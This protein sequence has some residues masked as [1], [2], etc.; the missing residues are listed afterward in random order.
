MTAVDPEAGGP[1]V[2]VITLR[3]DFYAHCA[4]YDRLRQA[5]AVH[6]AYIGPMSR[7][8]LRRAIEMPARQGGWD[9]EPGLVDLFLREASDE[10]GALPLLSHA[11]LETWQR[12][13]GR[14]LT[15][16]GYA[17]SGGVRGAIAQTAESLQQRL[18]PEQQRLAR[19]IF[20][21]LTELGEGT[22]DTRRRVALS[23][24]LGSATQQAQVAALLKTL[25]DARLVTVSE[26]NVEV[27]HEALIREWPTLREW[28]NED[29]EGLRLHR[30]LTEA[31]QAW[32]GLGRE[33]GEL[34]RGVRLAQALEWA[35]ARPD[36]L[37]TLEREFL[38]ASRAEVERH[39]AELEAQ[40][41]RELK[42]AQKL[43]EAEAHTAR[44]QAAAARRLRRRAVF[45]TGALAIAAVLALA[46]VWF[47][48]QAQQEARAALAREL[49]AGAVANLTVDPERSV[50]LAL[51][52]VDT[53]YRVDGT[54]LREAENALHQTIPGLRVKLSLPGHAAAVNDIALSPDGTRLATASNDGTAMIWDLTAG[55]P[56]GANRVRA[57]L[58]GHTDWLWGA[59]YSPDGRLVATAS[60]DGT[61][62]VWD[63]ETG[64]ALLQLADLGGEVGTVDFSPD[65]QYLA[66]G[67]AAGVAH[68]WRLREGAAGWAAEAAAQLATAGAGYVEF[69]PA[70]VWL[71]ADNYEGDRA[72]VLLWRLEEIV[73]GQVTP[74]QTLCCI[75]DIVDL[76]F[77]PDGARL[78]AGSD[79]NTANVWEVASGELLNTLYGHAGPVNGVA[80]D[81]A[82]DRLV[83]SS[84]DGSA[85]I[86]ALPPGA[87]GAEL[88]L[89][90]PG[91][92]G[93][94]IEAFF[95]HDG[96]SLVTASEGGSVTI[97]D[98]TPS[99]ERLTL[100]GHSDWV[101]RS[102]FSP[103]GRQLATA[104]FDVSAVVWD[105]LTGREVF[106]LPADGHTDWINGVVFSPDGRRLATA[107]NDATAK[108]WDIGS[109]QLL[110]TLAGHAYNAE[111]FP[112]QGVGAVVFSPDGAF[113]LTSGG[114]GTLR[115]WDAATGEERWALAA[116]EQVV[117]ALALSGDGTR[118]ATVGFDAAGKVWDVTGWTKPSAPLVLL[119][120]EGQARGLWAAALSPDGS[121]LAITERDGKVSIWDSTP[122]GS[123]T[124]PLH[125][126]VGHS[127]IVTGAAFSPDGT[128][129]A[130]ASF[131]GTAKV[132]DV[133]TGSEQLTL[134]G[135]SGGVTGVGFSPDGAQLVTTSQDGTARVYLLSIDALIDLARSRLTRTWTEDE[136]RR[137]LHVPRCPGAP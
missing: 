110:L 25:A 53:T 66:A 33:P 18:P 38:Q 129:L 71:A 89:T 122:G 84:G 6:Q 76:E 42:A 8:E 131:D 54:V 55:P 20:L 11:L 13:R 91:H 78:A 29:R 112:Y 107:S 128:R 50:L 83:T 36:D 41:Q 64:A 40:R 123:P 94:V 5:L 130:T 46:A 24:L 68:V 85:K 22:Q 10:P 120:L 106:R 47:G 103:D 49:A 51:A 28:L 67:T 81:T 97:W 19:A 4:Q 52:A 45:L 2:V 114:D 35:Q 14:S 63:A 37:N 95:L 15:H 32:E 111:G 135:H 30:H 58:S 125:T 72:N 99:R 105:A 119:T 62:R 80:F 31:A 1:T 90:L 70:G 118:L 108:V 121:R 115:L 116:H 136:C 93:S 88:V 133:A 101:W 126:L 74:T 23:E 34:Y 69:S 3:A 17:A 77:S 82:G 73:A 96:D 60:A 26:Q 137:F 104:G 127:S 98:I 9:F 12:R 59:A 61:A 39:A 134:S 109:G 87:A 92:V 132:W 44:Q 56:L 113:L 86:W 100:A 79:D 16:A 21:R 65:G 117:T 27:A 7:D 102:A 75:A 57:T 48:R 43:A 124:S